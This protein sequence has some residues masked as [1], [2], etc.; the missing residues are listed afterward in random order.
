MQVLLNAPHCPLH[1]APAKEIKE[2]NYLFL[3]ES[4]DCLIQKLSVF[5]TNEVGTQFVAVVRTF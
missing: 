3:Q 1:V 5:P 4:D 2:E